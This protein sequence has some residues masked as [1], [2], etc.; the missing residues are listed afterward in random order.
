MITDKELF[1]EARKARE[2]A[3]CPYSHYAVGAALLSADGQVFHGCNIE[4]SSYG[5]TICAERCAIFQA[6][7]QGIHDFLAIAIA[8]GPV[9][10]GTHDLS[11]AY[12][13]GVCR[14]V[15]SEFCAPDT[16]RILVG[17]D[18]EHLE[19]HLLK[20]LLPYSFSL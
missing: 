11:T 17:K 5:P 16:F 6:V 8:G 15:M 4:N 14:Q 18:T 7:S 20:E 2:N 9:S 13:C 1:Q 19:T 3:Y 12:P 10:Q